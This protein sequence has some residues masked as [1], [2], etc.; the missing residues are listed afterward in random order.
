[1]F[2]SLGHTL[3][4]YRK[5]AVALF[6]IGIL[7]AG[8][9]GSLI[10]NRLDSGGYSNPN[11]DS[12]KVYTYLRDVLKVQDPSVA[13]V[14]DAGNRNIDD[15]SVVEGALAL[16]KKMSSEKGVKIPI[17]GINEPQFSYD[18]ESGD[19]K[20]VH[21][22]NKEYTKGDKIKKPEQGKGKGKGKKGSND[23]TI[24]E[25][26]FTITISREEFLDY[27]FADLELPDLVKK[28]LNSI[29]DFKQKRSG[30]TN[31]GN[32]SRLNIT[33]SYKN[34][35]SR[36]M[37][38]SIFFKKKISCMQIAFLVVRCKAKCNIFNS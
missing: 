17:K 21:P 9:V 13:V 38:M 35:M 20:H 15:P 3:V 16:E 25:D 6:I 29:V 18:G 33:K 28:H 23:P 36:R 34:S 26:D 22:G 5:S 14:V 31:K 10:F 32:P 11:S 7:V 19:K 27:F 12:Y 2:E 4:K 30:F 8:G 1:M 24:T 37:A